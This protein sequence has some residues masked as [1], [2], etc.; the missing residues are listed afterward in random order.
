[1]FYLISPPET[2]DWGLDQDAFSQ[3]LVS[4][5]PA[6]RLSPPE[7]DSPTRSVVWAIDDPEGGSRWLEGSLDRAG[8][9][10]YLRGDLALAAEFA[11]WLR[12]KVDPRQPL[13]FSD[14][15]FT[16]VIELVDDG[17]AESIIQAYAM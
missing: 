10:H 4:E 15:A 16:H 17:S 7:P 8:Q 2:T 14:E 6:V 5:W 13:V 3:D 9:A 1:M 11:G 12:R